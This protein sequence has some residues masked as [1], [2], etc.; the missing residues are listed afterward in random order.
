MSIALARR[1]PSAFGG[2]QTFGASSAA[3]YLDKLTE[4]RLAHLR[5]SNSLRPGME[6]AI[7]ELHAVAEE[8]ASSGWDGYESTPVRQEAI[9]Q[10]ERFLKAL[11]LGVAAPSVGAEPDGHITFEWYQSPRRTLS[12][13]VSQEG[14][15][16]YAALLGYSKNYGTEPFL[17]EIPSSILNLVQ[18]AVSV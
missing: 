3:Q 16:H 12:V 18:R 2:M 6:V 7:E 8:C 13:S 17:G 11:P 5:K 1:A 14:D 10:A 9:R 15:V 4:E